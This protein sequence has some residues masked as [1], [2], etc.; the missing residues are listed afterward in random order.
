MPR[1]L[2]PSEDRESEYRKNMVEFGVRVNAGD[3]AAI[4]YESPYS[5]RYRLFLEKTRRIP[6]PEQTEA[7]RSG[8]LT[9]PLIFE[10]YRQYRGIDGVSQAWAIDDEYPWLQ[11]KADFWNAEKRLL[12]EFKAPSRDDAKDHNAAKA[13]VIPRHYLLQCIHLM[14]VFDAAEMDFVS[15]RSADDFAV[16]PVKRDPELW[17]ETMLPAYAIFW[18]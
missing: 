3:A 16:I 12:A 15:W 1:I 18:D 13:G 9:E 7:M 4:L 6:R 11:A 14:E 8:N 17:Y 5:N 10:W 2:M